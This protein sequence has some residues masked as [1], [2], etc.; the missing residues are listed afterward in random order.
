MLCYVQWPVVLQMRSESGVKL[1]SCD[2]SLPSKWNT[3][4]I[5]TEA[6]L[7]VREDSEV[8]GKHK[9]FL[10]YRYK[11]QSVNTADIGADITLKFTV[12]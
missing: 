7:F 11:I 2:Q 12:N 6:G 5:C 9:S 8:R 10:G 4:D 3:S 1:P